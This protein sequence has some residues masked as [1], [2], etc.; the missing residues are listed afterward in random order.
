MAN[1]D[2]LSGLDASFLSLERSGAHMHVGSVL[3]SRARRRPTRTS[4]RR[5]SSGCTSCRATARSSRIRRSCRP[6]P[7][8][9]DDPHFN[10]ALP[11]APHRA[12]RAR[13]RGGA[14]APRR[15][16]CSPR[17]WTAPSR[18]GSC[19]WSTRSATTRF[20]LVSKTHHALVDGVSGVDIST[21]LFD[22]EADPPE[23]DPAPRLVPA[24]G[25]EPA[26]ALL[27]PSLAERAG[28]PVDTSRG[29]L[30]AA[31]HPERAGAAAVGQGV[32]AMAARRPG[33]ARRR[34]RSTCGS[35]R[36]AGSRGSTPTST[37]FKAIKAALGGTVNDVVL[38]AVAG[39]LRAFLIRRGRDPEGL[40]LKAMVPV[41]VR[42]RGRARRARQ[43]RGGDVRAAAGLRA[44][45]GAALPD[46]P[47][48]DGRAEGVRAGGRRRGADAA[49]G[50]RG[51]DD[52]R[53][54]GA[55]A[56]APAVLQPRRDQR[57]RP[58]VPALPDGPQ[59]ARASTR[60]SRSRSTRRWA[61]RSCP[62][63]AGSA[64]AC[65]ATT[66]RCPSSTTLAGDLEASIAELAEVAGAARRGSKR[67]RGPASRRKAA[68]T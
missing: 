52:P 13:R 35:A 59:A 7:V 20:A 50:L 61:S 63:T 51:A 15:A 6:R 36:T 37:Q 24:P 45:R 33:R 5:S 21:V 1:P 16:A 60:R 17:A 65:S 28:A 64:S 55:A 27:A 53:P 29:A 68:A 12:A 58:A 11:R 9:I 10:A 4:W 40:E 22:L 26:P 49:G 34:A 39:A 44:R 14:Q 47:R 41:S 62:T 8:W 3:S 43:P 30:G 32:A 23:P 42:A 2:R 54:G 57:P 67:R 38:A 56:D 18:C 48:G 31:R 25:A 19:G 66:T 46:R